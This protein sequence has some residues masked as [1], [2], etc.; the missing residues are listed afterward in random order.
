M[1]ILK[2]CDSGLCIAS[3]KGRI[4]F[5]GKANELGNSI[6]T[7][8]ATELDA[9]GKLVLPGFIDSH[10]HA[11]FAGSRETELADKLAGRSYLE[12]LQSG[13][14]I[15]KTVRDT[16]KASDS[17][18]IEQTRDRL[19]RMLSYGT[20]T[21]EVK[22][23]YGLHVKTEIRLLE[24]IRELGKRQNCELVPT[25]LSAHA[26]PPEFSND[27]NSYIEQVVKPT[28]DHSSENHL[29]KFCDVFMEEGVFGFTQ[30]KDILEYAKKKN[31]ALKIHADEFSDLG[32][33]ELAAE[34]SATSADHLMKSSEK[35]MEAL[36]RSRTVSVLLPGTTLSSFAPTYAK[37]REFISRGCPVALATD[38]S[39]NS[40]IESM[41]FVI[42]LACHTMRLTSVE[43]IVGATINAAHA[44]GQ[45]KDLGS[46]EVGKSC[47]LLIMNLTNH[48]ELAY[49][50]ASN[51]VRTVIKKGRIVHT[52]S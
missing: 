47:D 20:T 51:N 31:L 39:P 16:R 48:N 44:I 25:L 50:I 38:L 12:I 6:D 23:G 45:A 10:T 30:T 37:A 22:T 40:W 11:I 28:I 34:L 27:P 32:G 52:V 17:E 41:Q 29:A 3:S 49:R 21:A 24:I 46:I 9:Q 36:S 5:V 4:I 18:I 14:G 15:L 13:G 2:D 26:I 33:A 42:S 7:S 35:G 1:G 8:S 19:K 43:A